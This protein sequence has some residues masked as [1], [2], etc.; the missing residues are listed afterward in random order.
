MTLFYRDGIFLFST[1][2]YVEMFKYI[3]I[4]IFFQ[5]FTALCALLVSS[6]YHPYYR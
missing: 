1:K 5:Q 2:I 6:L 3:L 4:G